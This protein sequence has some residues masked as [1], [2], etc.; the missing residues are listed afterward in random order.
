MNKLRTFYVMTFILLF[1]SQ[2][3]NVSPNVLERKDETL[4]NWD[5]TFSIK[6]YDP[7]FTPLN[8]KEEMTLSPIFTPDNALELYQSWINRANTTIDLQN[9]YIT[10]FDD[11]S[12]ASDSSPLVRSL[13]DAHNRGVAIRVQIREDSDS[14]DITSYFLSL[15][16]SVRWMG[17]QSNN[18][19]NDWLSYTHN[20]MVIIDN[21]VSIISSINFGENAFTNNREAGLIIQN[22]NVANYFTSIFNRDWDDGE[23]PPSTH[24]IEA[25]INTGAEKPYV[26]SRIQASYPSHTNIPK[27]NFTGTYN[28]TLFTNPDCADEVIFNYLKSAKTSIYV[29]MYTIS[30]PDFNDTLINLKKD[31]PGIDIQVLISN[32]RVGS[33]ENIDTISAAK[34]LVANGIP[35]YNSTKDDD[36][37]NGFYHNKYWIIDGKHVFVYSGNWSPRSVTPK[38]TSYTSTE[39]NRDT[40][41]AVHDALDI[42]DFY[43][44][45]WDAD[46]AVASAWELPSG[47]KLTTISQ[48]DVLSGTIAI[49]ALISGLTNPECAYRWDTKDWVNVTTSGTSFSESF[50]TSQLL[51]GIHTL[52]IRAVTNTQTY[53]D[54]VSVN[55]VNYASNENWRFLITELLPNPSEVSDAEGEYI[56]ITN[57]FPFQLFIEGWKVGDNNDLLSFPFNYSVDAY[58]SIIIAKS[59]TGFS[60]AYGFAP[61]F[62]LGFSLV[63]TGDYVQLLNSHNE[64]ID[65][66]AY[67]LSAPD[68]SE[69]LDIPEAGEAILRDPLHVDTDS[70]DDF[71]FGTPDP[72]GE[73]LHIPLSTYYSNPTSEEETSM[74][75]I[76][77]F[78]ALLIIPILRRKSR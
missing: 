47:I 19:D 58:S 38:K 32:R 71:I 1:I 3:S 9:Q 44:S 78:P 53:S 30:R 55:I 51:N 39:A 17:S 45:V 20:K 59:S 8:L 68:G 2:I 63:N 62:E 28:V 67:G 72:K 60:N 25:K 14:D 35:V 61:D 50:D 15:G 26:R 4:D 77:I 49:N 36:K 75:L 65:V 41:I 29:S 34:S 18:P 57:S 6:S 23:I 42:A 69:Q 27:T 10:K 46:V 74:F 5:P 7:S 66:V 54:K 48:A 11:G 13:I 16:I 52:E 70:A 22:T 24:K 21:K 40:G 56:E 37:V 33:S 76:S 64:Y 12:W 43:K 73:V 31:N